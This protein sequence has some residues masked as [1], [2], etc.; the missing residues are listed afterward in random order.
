MRYRHMAAK[1]VIRKTVPEYVRQEIHGDVDV[2]A[3]LRPGCRSPYAGGDRPRAFQ[4]LGVCRVRL[5]VVDDT[6][7]DH[8]RLGRRHPGDPVTPRDLAARGDRA[9]TPDA[10]PQHS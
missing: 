2:R 5:Q 10:N 4:S 6:L 9:V 1:P 7:V 3:L 8:F